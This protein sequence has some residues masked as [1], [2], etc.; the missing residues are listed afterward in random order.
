MSSPVSLL[1]SHPGSLGLQGPSEVFSIF[2]LPREPH[3]QQGTGESHQRLNIPERSLAWPG[4]AQGRLH[5][6]AEEKGR[7]PWEPQM[8]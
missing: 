4:L 5:L 7:L 6:T 2:R 1:Y 3:S 8:T